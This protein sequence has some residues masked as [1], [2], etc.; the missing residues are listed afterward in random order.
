MNRS[1]PTQVGTD[2][3]WVRAWAFWGHSCGL[4]EDDTLWCW[5]WNGRGPLGVGDFE[6]RYVPTQVDV[7]AAPWPSLSSGR[8]G[9]V[10]GVRG[11]GS[12]WCWGDNEN[13]QLGLGEGAVGTTP[14]T[15]TTVGGDSDWA[16]VSVG[17]KFSCAVKTDG[18]LWCTGLNAYGQLGLGH[19]DPRASFTRVCFPGD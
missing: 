2:S 12:L 14:S 10:C 4:K 19:T 18:T 5:G 1:T 15:P 9:S 13:G 8:L 17:R 11:D 7:A 16:Q 6:F 3:D